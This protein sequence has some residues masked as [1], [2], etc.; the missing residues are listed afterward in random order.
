MR[1]GHRA[2]DSPAARPPQGP[3]LRLPTQGTPCGQVPTGV[4]F[5]QELV[6]LHHP[7]FVCD[8]P[9]SSRINLYGLDG[10]STISGLPGALSRPPTARPSQMVRHERWVSMTSPAVCVTSSSG[11]LY[12]RGV[13][14]PCHRGTRR[15]AAELF[16]QCCRRP[17]DRS[18][19]LTTLLGT[20]KASRRRSPLSSGV[21]RSWMRMPFV[22]EVLGGSALELAVQTLGARIGDM[23][24]AA[25]VHL[26]KT[27]RK[28]R[29]I[30]GGDWG[31]VRD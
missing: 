19:A 17:A 12:W 10:Q 25:S 8:L 16:R 18:I 24:K 22:A 23:E 28:G 29:L 13:H 3:V 30:C 31:A 11:L 2:E 4:P 14:L 15:A 21:I 6:F 7:E 26:G 5:V 27:A 1:D 20:F 9:T